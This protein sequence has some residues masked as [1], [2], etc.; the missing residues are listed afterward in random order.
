MS[1]P[2]KGQLYEMQLTDYNI[3]GSVENG[4]PLCKSRINLET[5][6]NYYHLRSRTNVFGSVFRIRSTIIKLIHDFYHDQDFLHLDPNILTINE[7][8]GGAG[9][10]QVTEND[11]SY[12][13][14]LITQKN[15]QVSTTQQS[16]KEET[17]QELYDW[18]S[19]HFNRPVYL[20]VSSQLQLE[21][22]AC[23]L[24]NVYTMNK[25]FRSEHS[26]TTKH[27]SEFT[28]LE[29][30]MIN[31]TLDDLM[32]ISENMLKY[33]IDKLFTIRI[34]DL[35]NLNKFIS[36]GLIDRLKNLTSQKYHR[37]SYHE[38]IEEI[39][40]DINEGKTQISALSDGDDLG[41]EHENYITQKYQ[42]A[43]FVTHWPIQIKSFYMRR[44]TKDSEVCES[45][46]LLMPYGIGELIGASQREENLELL[47][48]IMQRKG[49]SQED[50]S[51][52]LDLRRYGT[53][54]HG[55]FGLGLDR[56]VMLM[57]GMTNIRDV[58]PFPVCYKS[59]KY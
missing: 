23:S 15:K 6:R 11:I 12:P 50:L 31:N 8:E 38:V 56:L 2:A 24:G 17:K 44:P 9:A 27:V 18:H 14:K 16:L 1:S 5:L 19:D 52:Y 58:I 29:I 22:M 32:N 47:Q 39:N 35:E 41:S 28:H 7:C 3:V 55:G 57:T 20:T 45:F 43:V 54:P 40:T 13:S 59:C 51:F 53:C 25:S 4:Y 10:F 33:I 36:K 37:I 34:N 42:N 46:D 49:V 30:E 26:L 48:E 21:A